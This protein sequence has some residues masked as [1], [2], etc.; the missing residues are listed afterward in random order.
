MWTVWWRIYIA[1]NPAS[2]FSNACTCRLSSLGPSLCLNGGGDGVAWNEIWR[3]HLTGILRVA[4][5]ISV[6]SWWASEQPWQLAAGAANTHLTP[7]FHPFGVMEF[8][9]LIS[10]VNSGYFIINTEKLIWVESWYFMILFLPWNNI[11]YSLY[12]NR[13]ILSYFRKFWQLPYF[14]IKFSIIRYFEVNKF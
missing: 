7:G 13:T 9:C 1:S 10:M 12:P 11:M 6:W 3:W 8:D 2:Q 5:V 14:Y 4:I